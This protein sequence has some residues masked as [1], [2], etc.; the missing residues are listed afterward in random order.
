MQIV[1]SAYNPLTWR[2]NVPGGAPESAGGSKAEG[3]A[4]TSD[5]A[6][7]HSDDIS[8]LGITSVVQHFSAL[9]QS[10]VVQM[11][12]AAN[13]DNGRQ[14]PGAAGDAN[15]AT[16]IA[17]ISGAVTAGVEPHRDEAIDNRG[18][19]A[20]LAGDANMVTSTAADNG[21]DAAQS[22]T[23]SP[24]ASTF[25]EDLLQAMQAYIARINAATA[26]PSALNAAA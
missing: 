12:T 23:W 6:D 24:V 1:D 25:N 22:G 13:K 2:F 20:A 8:S 17:E 10:V 11:Q 9:M 26:G 4:K 21:S 14:G 3:I 7:G 16:G 5:I 19:T 15:G 18:T